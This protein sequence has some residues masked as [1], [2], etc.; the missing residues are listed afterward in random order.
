MRGDQLPRLVSA[1]EYA[2]SSGQDAIDLAHTAGLD[3]DPWQRFV[4]IKSLGR[5]ARGQW[6]APQV[7][8]TVSRQNGKGSILEARELAGLF[9]FPT[10][11]LMIHTAH[12]HKTAS[13]HFRRVWSLIDN[14]P[15]LSKQVA[16][17][18]SAY[19][20][21]FIETFPK[22]VIILGSGGRQVRQSEAK[23]LIFIARS[24][25]SGRG[26]TG[27]YLNYDEDMVLDA[28]RVGAS[29][30]SL[31]ARP[32]PQVWF[33]GSAGLPTS[34]QLALIRRRM[35]ANI[36]S[37]DPG[38]LAAF[39]WS[40]DWHHEYCPAGCTEHDDP[41]DPR[42]VARANPALGIRIHP[43]FVQ[44]EREAMESRE[45]QRERLGVGQYPAPLDGWLVVPLKWFLATADSA[46][47]PP[48]VRNPV[49]AIGAAP[50]RS[51]AA[52][53]V[54]GL[55]PD[56]L[57][58]LQVT[59][60]REGIGWLVNRA[61]A[62]QAKWRPARWIV[63]KRSAAGSVLGDLEKAGLPVEVVQATDVTHA[64]GQLYDAMRDETLRH[65]GQAG[66]RTALAGADK[67][68]LI[69]S[70]AFDWFNTGVDV[71]PLMAATY[72]HWGYLRFGVQEEYDTRDSV[73]F[74][75]AEIIRIYRAGVYGPDDIRRLRDE[76]LITDNDL[77]ALA[78]A[79]I[80][81]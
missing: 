52:I 63:D 50:D 32:N 65:Y 72:A 31:S 25:S 20:R 29:F 71:S 61:K 22:P 9:L 73:H 81:V 39:E 74:D 56:G 26:F 38:H 12:E 2:T 62:I 8:I 46:A 78:N 66:L 76:G 41:D 42:S 57:A 30:P 70:W 36:E 21:E 60:H 1:P 54:S 28:A 23:R 3:M 55:R 27:D 45:F 15:N 5:D 40:I 34:T 24:A 48:R 33:T 80:P 58:G 69:G 19:G 49:F 67:R 64:C 35:I 77:E 6:S 14:T 4:L 47:E 18:S 11:R 13:E 10:D 16:R 7:L 37:G 75:T 51:S 59:D 68:N 79:G 43:S 53:A 44:T 17:H